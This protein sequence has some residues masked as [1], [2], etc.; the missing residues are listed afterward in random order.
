MQLNIRQKLIVFVSITVALLV[1]VIAS[2]HLSFQAVTAR[3]NEVT[4]MGSALAALSEADMMHDAVRG[5]VYA[6]LLAASRPTASDGSVLRDF[7]QHAKTL[8]EQYANCRRLELSASIQSV[9]D[10][11]AE[12]IEHFLATAERLINQAI[13]APTAADATLPEF[14]KVF[15]QLEEKL[16]AASD[17][18]DK[19]A[20]SVNETAVAGTRQFMLGLWIGTAVVLVLLV[21]FGAS[22][23]RSILRQLF[24]ASETLMVTS[25][26]N[27]GLSTQIKQS[28]QTMAEGANTQAASLQETAASL[29]EIASMTRRNADAAGEAKKCSAA[30]RGTAD[31]GFASMRS[32]Q[33]AMAEIKAASDDITKILKAIDEIA[34]QTNILALNA[35]VEAARAGEAGAGFAV[36]AEEVRALAQ[37]SAQAARETAA[38]MEASAAKSRQG[39]AISD[40]VARNFET[41]QQ[42]IR[43]LDALVSEIAHASA[44]QSTGLGQLNS[45]VSQLDLVVQQNAATAQESAG[46]ATHLEKRI[47]ESSIVVGNLLRNSGGNRSNDALGIPGEPKPGGRRPIDRP[48]TSPQAGAFAAKRPPA[49]SRNPA[50]PASS[51]DLNFVDR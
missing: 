20:R 7:Q 43:Q 1:A 8:R 28:A 18:M 44:E 2:V 36:V 50:P 6:A 35:A 38:K 34:F 49:A 26:E 51:P 40:D 11:A 14:M 41:I 16:G 46:A 33:I 19:T 4:K 24:A 32:M 47:R 23:S 42:Q 5:D 48:S 29:E 39:V 17:N 27:T 15:A 30:A 13:T 21:V 31:T 22:I 37:R 10:A 12:P 45:S 3:G 25:L 9:L